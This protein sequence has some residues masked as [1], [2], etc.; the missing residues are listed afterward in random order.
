MVRDRSMET[1]EQVSFK[2]NLE[3]TDGIELAE[4]RENW[5]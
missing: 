2:L 1:L 3:K 4:I 5:S